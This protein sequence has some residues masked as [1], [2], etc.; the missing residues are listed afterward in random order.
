[1]S[2]SLKWETSSLLEPFALRDSHKK[3]TC[4]TKSTKLFAGRKTNCSLLSG[5]KCSS[6]C[7]HCALVFTAQLLTGSEHQSFSWRASIQ[8][9]SREETRCVSV[10]VWHYRQIT[11]N[12]TSAFWPK[13]KSAHLISRLCSNIRWVHKRRRLPWSHRWGT[14]FCQGRYNW[15]SRTRPWSHQTHVR[16]VERCH[17]FWCCPSVKVSNCHWHNAVTQRDVI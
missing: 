5:M 17:W 6:V 9:W 12:Q 14:W 10:R 1:M 11:V 16:F 13:R 7:L 2:W 8:S 15:T 4:L 3:K